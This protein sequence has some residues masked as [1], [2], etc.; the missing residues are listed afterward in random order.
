VRWPTR[1][2][3]APCPSCSEDDEEDD[4]ASDSGG[5]DEEFLPSKDE[6]E[7]GGSSEKKE[8]NE[9]S[10][11]DEENDDDPKRKGEEERTPKAAPEGRPVHAALPT[12]TQR[13]GHNDGKGGETTRGGKTASAALARVV[14]SV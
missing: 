6:E 14:A 4:T 12:L 3:N 11:G 8:Q 9:A 10:D 7:G 5:S 2:L 1:N 13:R